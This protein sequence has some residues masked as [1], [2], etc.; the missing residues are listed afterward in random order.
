[1]IDYDKVFDDPILGGQLAMNS[2][3]TYL[4][5]QENDPFPDPGQF[6]HRSFYHGLAGDYL[7]AAAASSTGSAR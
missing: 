5:R 7:R 2:N 4:S 6:H 1:M 3:L